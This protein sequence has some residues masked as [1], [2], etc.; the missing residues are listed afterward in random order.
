MN[1]N[2]AFSFIDTNRDRLVDELVQFL[3][4]PSI[5][6][7]KERDPDVEAALDYDRRKLESLGFRTEIWPT[8]SHA[9][10]FAERTVSPDLPTV[11]IYGHVD[12][13]PV[14]PLALW[15]S[16]PFEP[17]IADGKIWARGADDNK[18]QHYAQ[19]AGVEAVLRGDGELPVN[20]KFILESDEEH[21]GEAMAAE[22]PKHASKLAC[23]VFVVSDSNFP[24][25]DHPAV[26]LSLRGIQAFEITIRGASG[27]KHSGEWGGMLYEPIDV[28]RWTLQNLK[29]FQ[30][31]RVLV[32]GFYDDVDPPTPETRAAIAGRP[33]DDAAQ[34]RAQGVS[35]LFNEEGYTSLESG[36]LRPTLQVNGIYGGY[37]GEGFKTVI[38]NQASAKIS[39]RL[40]ARQDPEKIAAAFERRVREL[41][42]DMGKVEIRKFGSGLPFWS[43]PKNPYVQA[44]LRALTAAFGKPAVMLAMGGSIPIVP[45]VV[46]T[47]GA[48]CVMMGFGLPEDNLHAPNENFPVENYLGGAKAAAAFLHEV[49]GV[50]ERVPA[51]K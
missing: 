11:L 43:D 19:I 22:L 41:V 12:V 20:V 23:D 30:T 26:T 44:G 4:I 24:D 47:T 6:A 13:Q 38:G 36:T 45:A 21:D 16:P 35:R 18:G 14:D 28:L 8:R 37:T 31:G 32:S 50:R 51:R 40:V 1:A 2:K 25:R 17:R 42:G 5:S 46:R 48:A 15:T 27:D 7:H 10:L 3:R 49:A 34:A 29:D 39:M 9:G 33:W